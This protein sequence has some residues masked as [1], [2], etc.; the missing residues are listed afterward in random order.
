MAADGLQVVTS[1]APG[2][3]ALTGVLVDGATGQQ[4]SGAIVSL[5]VTACAPTFCAR[6]A[7]DGPEFSTTS[8]ASGGFAFIDVPVGA[9]SYISVTASGYDSFEFYEDFWAD[10]T[11]DVSWEIPPAAEHMPIAVDLTVDK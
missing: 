8:D 10:E 9:P 11:Y 6:P 4:I 1:T 2:T 3:Y 7:S 5:R